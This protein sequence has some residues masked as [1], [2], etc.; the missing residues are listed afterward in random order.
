M[1]SKWII[2]I[3]WWSSKDT[4]QPPLDQLNQQT[5]HLRVCWLNHCWITVESLES[6]SLTSLFHVAKPIMSHSQEVYWVMAIAMAI[7]A[8]SP[9]RQPRTSGRWRSFTSSWEA[10]V[11]QA[12]DFFFRLKFSKTTWGFTDSKKIQYCTVHDWKIHMMTWD[13]WDIPSAGGNSGSQSWGAE[14]GLPGDGTLEDTW[15]RKWSGKLWKTMENHGKPKEIWR[16][17]Q[18]FVSSNEQ[19]D[20]EIWSG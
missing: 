11:T 7:T 6:T 1:G 8:S 13:R 20:F 4:P 3:P 14:P 16:F 18:F 12:T 5:L 15:A 9:W 10:I 17:H 19:P 2:M